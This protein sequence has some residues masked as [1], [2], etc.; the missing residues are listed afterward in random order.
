MVE[1]DRMRKA[2]VMV[3]F[4]RNEGLMS[5][6]LAMAS[7]MGWRCIIRMPGSFWGVRVDGL[8]YAISSVSEGV[9]SMP[10]L[11]RSLLQA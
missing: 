1:I 2:G 8:A 6:S 7:E 5:D 9:S 10:R 3:G 11:R 4:S